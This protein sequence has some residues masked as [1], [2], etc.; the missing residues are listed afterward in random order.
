MLQL[1][2]KSP[3]AR[4]HGPVVSVP[5]VIV[6]RLMPPVPVLVVVAPLVD[7][8][9]P[10]PEVELALDPFVAV[11]LVEVPVVAL[12][13]V[14]TVVPVVPAP[15]VSPPPLQPVNALIPNRT[16]PAESHAKGRNRKVIV[17]SSREG[18]RRVG[19]LQPMCTRSNG[20]YPS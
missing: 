10:V 6:H 19:T 1:S 20:S 4:Q 7:V 17:V 2:G 13:P 12:V 11:V 14:E 9:D 16:G 8:V 3:L 18:F 5:P 15:P